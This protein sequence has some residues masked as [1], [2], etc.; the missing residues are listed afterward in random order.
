MKDKKHIIMVFTI[1]VSACFILILSLQMLQPRSFGEHGN[2]RWDAMAEI[3]SQPVLN[4][5]VTVCAECHTEINDLHSKDAHYNVP[6]VDCHGAG[7]L[8]AAY[9]RD[10]ANNAIISPEQAK[11]PK[12][13]TLEGC[14]RCHSKLKARPK[15]FP[16]IDKDQHYEFL[17][18]ID[19]EA[20]CVECHNPH[21]PIFLLTDIEKSKLHPIIQKCSFCHDKEPE[22]DFREIKDH[23][24]VFECKDCHQEIVASFENSP[25]H[26]AIECT[27]CHLFHKENETAGR[28]FKI[29]NAEFCL[30]CHEE[31]PY[32]DP[33]H[34]PKITWPN[35][36]G[37]KSALVNID[38]KICLNCHANAIHTMISKSKSSPHPSNWVGAHTAYY[39]KRAEG[40]RS[41]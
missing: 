30:L 27:S 7:N 19:S 29:G 32:K 24:P 20:K 31:K 2:F 18:V 41:E 9:Y 22:K 35:H 11:L 33:S 12:E 40:V 8:H 13:Y 23:P 5:D 4:Q 36:L 10:S 16:Q 37:D 1:V 3:V 14:L 17:K 38:R 39:K 6:C 26:K 15:D 34:P 21:E 25:H 28:M